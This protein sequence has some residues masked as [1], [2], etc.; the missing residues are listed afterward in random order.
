[1]YHLD[2]PSNAEKHNLHFQ[3]GNGASFP[4]VQL[5]QNQKIKGAFASL[6]VIFRVTHCSRFNANY[7]RLKSIFV[8]IRVL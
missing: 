3:N 6:A 1:M 7:F 5:V 8:K 4:F 2:I